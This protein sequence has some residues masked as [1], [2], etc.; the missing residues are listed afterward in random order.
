MNV[1]S[2]TGNGL[3]D[4][5]IQR[6]TAVVLAIYIIFLTIFIFTHPNLGFAGWH[7]LNSHIWM[8]IFSLLV[9]LSLMLHA[10]IGIWTVGTDYIKITWLRMIFNLLVIFSLFGFLIWGVEILWSA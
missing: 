6:V 8:R 1:M 5:I 3:R 9:L 7:D 2:L 10:W 4:W